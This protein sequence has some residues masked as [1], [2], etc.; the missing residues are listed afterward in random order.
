M[1]DVVD[2]GE[3]DNG[4]QIDLRREQILRVTLAEVR[5]AGFRWIPRP[6]GQHTLSLVTDEFSPPAAG[7]G[8]AAT[9]HWDFRAD[10]PG[11]TEITLEYRRPWERAAPDT[12]ARTFTVSV[13]VV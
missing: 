3:H 13:R 4:K 2:V 10:Q 9:H 12:A 5:T 7:P 11:E 8:G 1:S 6:T